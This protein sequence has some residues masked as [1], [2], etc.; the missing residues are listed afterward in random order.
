MSNFIYDAIAQHISSRRKGL[1]IDINCP[2]CVHNGQSRNDTRGRGGFDLKPGDR[3]VYGCFNC[4]HRAAYVEGQPLYPNMRRLLEWIGIPEQERTKLVFR[5]AA[6]KRKADGYR[7]EIDPPG[8]LKSVYDW[9]EDHCTDLRLLQIANFLL[10]VD[11]DHTAFYWTPD[12]NGIHLSQYIVSVF[13]TLDHCTGW[14]AWPYHD[15]SLPIRGHDG[16]DDDDRSDDELEM[17]SELELF[18]SFLDEATPDEI[19][20][21]AD[22][23]EWTARNPLLSSEVLQRVGWSL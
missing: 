22:D 8:G 15:P 5:A 10:E 7:N 12:D 21:F 14:T 16:I 18:R 19:R 4:G 3:L 23:A 2:A 1:S 17:P 11:A 13:G 20:E 9:L 6:M